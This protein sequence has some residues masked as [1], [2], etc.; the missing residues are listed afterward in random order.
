MRILLFVLGLVAFL[1]G[2]S[3][4]AVAQSA[5]HEIEAF[6]LFLIGAVFVSGAAIVEAVNG[7]RKK[8][9][10]PVHPNT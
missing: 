9:E 8:L 6:I 2:A 3:V 10:T 7:V 4:M 5:V 1:C